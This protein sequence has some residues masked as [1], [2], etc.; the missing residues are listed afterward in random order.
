[1]KAH[2]SWCRNNA[3]SSNTKER[4]NT[5]GFFFCLKGFCSLKF[6]QRK[7]VCMGF[8]HWRSLCSLPWVNTLRPKWFSRALLVC[9]C[10]VVP[11]VHS[12]WHP[13][14]QDQTLGDQKTLVILIRYY[15]CSPSLSLSPPFSHCWPEPYTLVL[16]ALWPFLFLSTL[17]PSQ[18]KEGP[19][20][21]QKVGLVHTLKPPWVHNSDT[22]EQ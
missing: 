21:G 12:A 16:M 15:S 22:F 2:F 14:A 18:D 11:L 10:H 13:V 17:W 7:L 20:S 5:L 6:Q 1:M 8:L 9:T 4:E 3:S 19:A